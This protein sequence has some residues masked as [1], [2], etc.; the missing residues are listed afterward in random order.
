MSQCDRERCEHLSNIFSHSL[1]IPANVVIAR[2]GAT[3]GGCFA[4]LSGVNSAH[5]DNT[6]ISR[7]DIELI[8]TK[9]AR[10]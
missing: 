4:S 7:A 5:S 1:V 10:K 9:L 6:D 2:D 3:P 8:L